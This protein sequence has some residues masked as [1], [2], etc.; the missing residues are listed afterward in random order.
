MKPS[1]N[2]ASGNFQKVNATQNNLDFFLSSPQKVVK[3]STSKKL[4]NSNQS[5]NL[6]TTNEL[7]KKSLL[8]NSTQTPTDTSVTATNADDYTR[9]TAGGNAR[10]TPISADFAENIEL[11]KTLLTDFI[12]ALLEATPPEHKNPVEYAIDTLRYANKHRFLSNTELFLEAFFVGLA[13]LNVPK[14]IIKLT[15]PILCEV[16]PNT[17]Q[18]LVERGLNNANIDS[19]FDLQFFENPDYKSDYD[20]FAGKFVANSW[21]E[22][23][24]NENR[25]KFEP[26]EV[27]EMPPAEPEISQAT[28]TH[29]GD[30]P[31]NFNEIKIKNAEAGATATAKQNYSFKL[32]GVDAQNFAK[33]RNMSNENFTTNSNLTTN[34]NNA[35]NDTNAATDATNSASNIKT[36]PAK[37]HAKN[38]KSNADTAKYHRKDY[39]NYIYAPDPFTEFESILTAYGLVLK[40]SLIEGKITRHGNTANPNGDAGW[41]IYYENHFI[42]SKGEEFEYFHAAYGD[43]SDGCGTQFVN[44]TSYDFENRND[45]PEYLKEIQKIKEQANQKRLEQQAEA[46]RLIELERE[47]ASKLATKI[48]NES[49]IYTQHYTAENPHPY[50]KKKNLYTII[51]KV[52]IIKAEVAS[53]LVGEAYKEKSNYKL[54][55]GSELKG[56]LLVIPMYNISGEFTSLQLIDINGT[57]YFLKG[58]AKSF[59][60]ITGN[61]PTFNNVAVAEGLATGAS[62][63]LALPT[64]KV[65]ISFDAGNL[66][67]TV[68]KIVKANSN[69]KITIFADNDKESKTGEIQAKKA[70]AD[71]KKANVKY[72][73]P[74]PDYNDFNDFFAAEFANNNGNINAVISI[75]KNYIDSEIS[76]EISPFKTNAFGVIDRECLGEYSKT[77][78]FHRQKL[79]RTE[80]ENDCDRKDAP[81]KLTVN[82][83]LMAMEDKS[84]SGMEFAFD[85]FKGQY[86]IKRLYKNSNEWEPFKRDNLAELANR[87]ECDN[88]LNNIFVNHTNLTLYKEAFNIFVEDKNIDTGHELIAKIPK[89]DGIPRLKNF[90]SNYL[91]DTPD[92]NNDYKE[93]FGFSLFLSKYARL[94]ADPNK[95]IEIDVGFGLYQKGGA[96]G[97][98]FF[99]N[100]LSLQGKKDG[101]T[102]VSLKA[103][104]NDN[105]KTELNRKMVAKETYSVDELIGVDHLDNET[106]KNFWTDPFLEFRPLYK[107]DPVRI[108]RRGIFLITTN[109]NKNLS[110]S[111]TAM[112]R[113]FA[114][115]EIDHSYIKEHGHINNKE[116]GGIIENLLQ[117]FAEAKHFYDTNGGDDFVIDYLRKTFLPL[118]KKNNS[119]FINDG[120]DYLDIFNAWADKV[121]YAGDY[122]NKTVPVALPDG[123]KPKDLPGLASSDVMQFCFNFTKLRDK[124][125]RQILKEVLISKG[126]L[127]EGEESYFKT[128]KGKK[129]RGY[130]NPNFDLNKCKKYSTLDDIDCEI[131]DSYTSEDF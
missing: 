49:D 36:P 65:F 48:Y 43:W 95:G 58:G 126:Y 51:E 74:P 70:I 104:N 30:L 102:N 76:K 1:N 19:S 26:C 112:Q 64:H 115:L 39:A 77:K 79:S 85:T 35:E 129:Q 113:R 103:L 55:A 16:L 3:K 17:T 52:K 46:K 63:K 13:K 27:L 100:H 56:D 131:K 24:N 91:N 127:W 86:V 121:F 124:K 11:N 123:Y 94:N 10:P 42:T 119:Q 47:F 80:L 7:D 98:T 59:F 107:D 9:N 68:G 25:L 62:I 2:A 32:K 72:I 78:N 114:F 96:V 29:G 31:N 118:L 73:M 109:E 22:M 61:A 28:G 60:E 41:A 105:S 20:N 90:V 66:S 97:K 12:E 8:D 101:V 67:N 4:K 54:F 57:K 83:I 108:A 82:N 50:L 44:I 21:L 14:E 93:A 15:T 84:F 88:N 122:N 89:W 130:I 69:A 99:V 111:D 6:T 117:L 45:D 81:I 33:E 87:I 23:L 128:I 5:S 125:N 92:V 75:M 106:L 18:E 38:Q 120:G 116:A 71:N 110:A 37:T 53:K 34:N 40:K